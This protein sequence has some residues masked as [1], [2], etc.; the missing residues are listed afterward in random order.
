MLTGMYQIFQMIVCSET[1]TFFLV[2]IIPNF[3]LNSKYQKSVYNELVIMLNG[4]DSSKRIPR[5][6]FSL[7]G[8][9]YF[10]LTCS[11]EDE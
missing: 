10:I 9:C 11:W 6:H 1:L 3:F 7:I 8:L 5:V 2:I 4:T